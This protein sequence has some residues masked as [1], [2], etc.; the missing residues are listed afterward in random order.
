LTNE[1]E[2]GDLISLALPYGLALS[3]L[4]ALVMSLSLAIAPDMW[5][6]DYPP[7][8]REKYG[9]MS[10]RA[11]RFRPMIGVL[12]FG[13]V[14]LIMAASNLRLQALPGTAP[15]FTDYLLSNLVTLMVFNLFDLLI[16]DW[17]LFV[18][19]QPSVIVLPGT[20]GMA[21]YKNYRFHFR[22]FLIGTVGSA[23]AAGILA[24][25]ALGLVRILA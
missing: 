22:A 10:D 6:S 11:K 17:L 8:I 1:M 5:L 3:L 14:L 2:A 12:F 18:T 16:V 9:P 4:I 23:V 20:E 7:D 24:A 13:A 15:R 21:G 25:I 19:I